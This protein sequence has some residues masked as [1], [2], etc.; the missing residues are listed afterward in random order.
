MSESFKI[1]SRSS[2]ANAVTSPNTII[3]TR[4]ELE[5]TFLPISQ[6]LQI[7]RVME[8]STNRIVCE[9]DVSKHWVFPLHFPSD[10]V[11]PG[12]LLIEAAGQTV[13]S[14]A[15]H[16]GFRGKPRLVKVVARFESCVSP[17]DEVLRLVGTVR[18]R[19]RA[20]WGVVDLYV[21]ER[22]VA[23]VEPMVIIIS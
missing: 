1:M 4:S 22:K 5:A 16:A 14:L 21:L 3:Y 13:A 20:F 23:Q 18:Q 11:F 15:W 9:M 7:D 17:Q 6:M 12:S 2:L 10:P 8:I 19:K